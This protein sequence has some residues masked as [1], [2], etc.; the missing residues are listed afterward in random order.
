MGNDSLEKSGGQLAEISAELTRLAE[1]EFQL[2]EITP[3]QYASM[4]YPKLLPMMRFCVHQYAVEGFGNL[5]TMDTKAMGGLMK[6]STIVLTP[7]SGKQVPFLLID[8]ME[9]KKKRLAYVE[10]YDCTKEGA[11]AG[12]DVLEQPQE[13]A[14]IPDYA[15]KAA[16]YVERRTPYSLIK[17]GEHAS[18]QDLQKM[19]V[20]CVKRYFKSA[21]TAKADPQNLVGL[22][23]FQQEMCT[24]GNPSTDT[25]TK[26]LGSDGARRFF[27]TVIM[28]VKE[29]EKG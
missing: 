1:Q 29:S 13:F 16:W 12:A 4:K 19:V 8:T 7:N 11:P 18:A 20:T 27:E 26:V 23:T 5:M 3:P 14:H 21:K 28:P 9:M 6:L 10:Y 15:E 24:L 17:G 2:K 22:K 25:L